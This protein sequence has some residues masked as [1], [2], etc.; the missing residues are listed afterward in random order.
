MLDLD[1]VVM[2]DDALDDEVQ[3]RLPVG[4]VRVLQPSRNPRA[5]SREA[6]K[7]CARTL[8]LLEAPQLGVLLL[9]QSALG[10]QR[11][12]PLSKLWRLI[13]SVP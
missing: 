8:A 2:H 5:E 11:L 12:A 6:F 7:R 13:T 9:G 3:D 1:M 4:D 10:S